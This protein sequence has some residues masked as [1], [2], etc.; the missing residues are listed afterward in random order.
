MVLS[1]LVS[2]TEAVLMD[3]RGLSPLNAGVAFEIEE[4]L[5]LVPL[6]RVVFVVDETTDETFLRETV[7]RSSRRL[8][9]TS[10]N[11]LSDSTEVTT[12]E[13]TASRRGELQRLLGALAAAS[14]A[15][16]EA[17]VSYWGPEKFRTENR[18]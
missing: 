3:L 11:R 9:P 12:F 14:G 5:N 6:E 10:P 18:V 15:A 1:R 17:A 4:L 7:E 2:E 13:F 8:R 16:P